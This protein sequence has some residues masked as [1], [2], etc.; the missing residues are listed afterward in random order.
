M[1]GI[2]FID[3]I[4]NTIGIYQFAHVFNQSEAGYGAQLTTDIEVHEL[5]YFHVSRFWFTPSLSETSTRI[6]IKSGVVCHWY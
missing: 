3:R 6:N 4:C 1:I 5:I 2:N